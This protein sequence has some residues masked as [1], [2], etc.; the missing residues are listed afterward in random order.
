MIIGKVKI[1][2][3][4]DESLGVR[5]MCIFVE[6][7][8]VKVIF[9]AGVSLAP[10]RYGLPPHPLEFK[11]V[12]EARQ[13]IIEY[14][15]KAD[16]VTV[17]HYHFD[18]FTPSF[19]SWYEWIDESTYKLIYSDKVILAKD[20]EDNINFNQRKRG[21]VFKSKIEELNSKL[22]YF[23][24]S[25]MLFGSTLIEASPPLPHGAEGSKLGWVLAFTI[26]Y[27]NHKI[28]YAPDVQGPISVKTLKYILAIK[29]DVLIIGGPPLYLA[30]K[31]VSGAE[32]DRGFENM[33]ILQDKIKYVLVSHHVLRDK[34]WRSKIRNNNFLLFSSLYGNKKS[35]FLE[36]YRDFLYKE[37]PPSQNFLEWINKYRRA[38]DINKKPPLD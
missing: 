29:P 13:R 36:A 15:E 28:L 4:A 2:P 37:Y 35:N 34:E 18:H 8:D 27:K 24:N 14:A 6:T 32:V 10:R 16:V 1:L 12:R 7:P 33:S 26:S 9:D 20:I 5:S 30:G 23:D 17:S 31:K 3:L 38:K 11:A 19:K 22:I 21:I 25:R